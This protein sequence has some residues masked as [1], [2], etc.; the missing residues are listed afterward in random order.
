MGIA[1][2]LLQPQM[3]GRMQSRLPEE[4]LADEFVALAH[5][6]MGSPEVAT[7]LAPAFASSLKALSARLLAQWQ[8]RLPQLQQQINERL[9]PLTSGLRANVGTGSSQSAADMLDWAAEALGALETLPAALT[10][11]GLRATVRSVAQF[12]SDELGLSQQ[13]L[14]DELRRTLHDVVLNLRGMQDLDTEAR[15][16]AR[17]LACFLDRVLVIGLDHLPTLDLQPDRVATQLLAAL[18]RLGLEELRAKFGCML[19]K[20]R[21]TLT[22]A[23]AL[24]RAAEVTVTVAPKAAKPARAMRRAH[25]KSHSRS[26]KNVGK[27]MAAADAPPR[28]EDDTF[29]WYGS[30]LCAHRRQGHWQW[31]PGYPC[32][33]VW[34]SNDRQ[35][36]VLRQVEGSDSVLHSAAAPFAWHEAIP[37]KKDPTIPWSEGADFYS[38]SFFPPEFLEVFTRVAD[39]AT[40]TGRGIWHIV[41][42]AQSPQEY[43]NNISQWLWCWLRAGF[44]AAGLPLAS[45][46]SRRADSGAGS[47]FFMTPMLTWI[48][49]IAT[50]FEGMHTKTENHGAG[51]AYWA[52]LFGTDMLN[53]WVPYILMRGSHDVLLS[54]FTLLN[55]TG[56]DVAGTVPCNWQ[57]GGPVIGGITFLSLWLYV[58]LIPR[59]Y[60]SYPFYDQN[61]EVFGWWLL[62]APLVGAVGSALGAL[63]V[64]ALSRHVDGTLLAKELGWGAL[65]GLRDFVL[66]FYLFREGDTN[67][68]RY[69]PKVDHEH[70]EYE[71]ARDDFDGYPPKDS[72]PYKLPYEKDVHFFIGQA[73]LGMFSHMA[74]HSKDKPQVYAIDFAH[75]FGDVVLA[76]RGGTVVDWFDWVPDD[77]D[78]DEATQATAAEEAYDFMAEFEPPDADGNK[79]P[80][81]WRGKND[82]TKRNYVL[83]RHDDRDADHDKGLGGVD[84]TTY[85]IYMHG[86][87]G[88]VRKVFKDT[89][90][91]EPPDIIGTRVQQG[92]P[93]MQAGDTGKS[94]HNHL[95]MHLQPGPVTP[96]N[97]ADRA[98][99]VGD[100][101]LD[102]VTLPFVFADVPDD[103]VPVRLT[104]YTSGN[105]PVEE[106]P[107]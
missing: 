75:D 70:E 37:F 105:D 72:S 49:V 6:L 76:S 27:N 89:Y 85:A 46:F 56:P 69:T 91:I 3:L 25:A 43:G 98:L 67:D 28:S 30:W 71:P 13:L 51:F 74:L 31:L 44:S 100:D 2:I 77:T 97:M 66:Y 45:A 36:L 11:D 60:Y 52:T 8:P 33:E 17:A 34:H 101:T 39:A 12:I 14:R 86:V 54:I 21:A 7:A 19:G 35:K 82:T 81:N 84:V 24:A 96:P 53:T 63:T 32:D 55:Q 103:G 57:H 18:R 73:H 29:C 61:W 90:N 15:A 62:G 16:T 92:N 68:G 59:E 10:D 5:R 23:A 99:R 42:M 9:A 94:M 22:A 79:T 1:S 102:L 106:L 80:R 40:E 87:N 20:L 64:W 26:N 107:A 88:S 58:E 83:I 4:D 38:F 78:P 47:S 104:W 50:S 65:R 95:H 93:I 48:L 41:R